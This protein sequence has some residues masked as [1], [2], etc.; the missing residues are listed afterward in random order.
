VNASILGEF[1]V[2]PATDDSYI[3][4]EAIRQRIPCLHTVAAA[5]A[6]VEGIA[7]RR[8]GH[9]AVRSLQAYHEDIGGRRR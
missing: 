4:K 5:K 7:A 1:A 6:A 9:S 2:Q 8:N 3:R